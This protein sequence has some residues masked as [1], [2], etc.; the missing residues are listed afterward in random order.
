MTLQVSAVLSIH[1]RG[2]LFE[3]ALAG[4]LWQTLP[5]EQWEI[6]LVDDCSTE[7]LR[8]R[9][10]H[11]LGQINL[12]H[13]RLDHQRHALWKQRNP[14]WRPGEREDWFHTP[15]LTINAGCALARGS[16][17]CLCHPE[18]LHAPENFALATERLIQR[19]EKSFLF[20][21]T[22][23][24]NGETDRWLS[25]RAHDWTREGWPAFLSAV[26]ARGL[27]HFGPNELYW[28]TSFLPKAA[29]EAVRGVDFVY[30]HG[31]AAEDDDFRDRVAL[32]GWQ[33]QYAT[34]IQGLHQ[35][36]SAESELHRDRTSWQWGEGLRRN[37]EVYF[38][39]RRN[40]QYPSVVNTEQPWEALECVVEV[41]EYPLA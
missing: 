33:A 16:V 38:H 8:R 4:Y 14:N 20:G 32:A 19:Q 17:I 3:R 41:Q 12:R 37:R 27:Q 39:R 26:N 36:H 10:A 25:S 29:V 2:Q 7:D 13:V 23:L 22:Y 6:V 1:N 31:V 30:L 5:R 11:V 21:L 18:I 40:Q 28:Y 15:A 34:D 35:D 9:Y 24:G